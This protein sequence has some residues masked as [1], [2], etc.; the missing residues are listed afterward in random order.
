MEDLAIERRLVSRVLRQW[1]ESCA[2]KR[3]P[4]KDD[5]GASLLGEDWRSC[6]LVRIDPEPD[7][8]TLVVVGDSLLHQGESLDGSVVAACPRGTLL[9]MILR[10]LPRFRPDGGPMSVTGSVVHCGG[11]VLFRSVL[12]PLA[13]DGTSIDHI[14]VATNFRALQ[15]GEDKQLRTRLEVLMLKVEPGQIW[16]VYS[17]LQS[18]WVEAKVTA[19]DG[20]HATLRQKDTRQTITLKPSEM[21]HRPERYRFISYA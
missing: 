7:H 8:S 17:P 10:Y 9:K 2:G 18:A 1:T 11:P 13:A 20:R 14:L 6:M 12:L 4:S 19:V 15:P 5:I 21:T 16:D 3:F